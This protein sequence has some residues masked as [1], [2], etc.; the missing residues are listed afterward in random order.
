[1]SILNDVPLHMLHCPKQTIAVQCKKRQNEEE[2][3]KTLFFPSKPAEVFVE[4]ADGKYASYRQ[5]RASGC[6]RN[7]TVQGPNK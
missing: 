3:L 2:T 1:M 7:K 5:N 4:A 6:A